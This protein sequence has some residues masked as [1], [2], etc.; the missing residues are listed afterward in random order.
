MDKPNLLIR[1]NVYPG[2][3]FFKED[4]NFAIQGQEYLGIPRGSI[5]SR[6][7]QA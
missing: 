7:A 6:T 1:K 3:I 5:Q 4:F 2:M